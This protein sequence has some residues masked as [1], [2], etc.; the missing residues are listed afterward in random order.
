[1]LLVFLELVKKV[2][3]FVIIGQTIQHFGISKKYEKYMKFMIS[4]IVVAQITFA[5]GIYIKQF[6]NRGIFM[7]GSEYRNEWET[8]MKK[9]EE[10]ITEY[11]LL[12]TQSLEKEFEESEYQTNDDKKEESGGIYVEKIIIP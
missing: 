9:V 7:S 4:I 5:F 8:N 1:M 11:N 12:L 10:K 2:G 3:I 6:K